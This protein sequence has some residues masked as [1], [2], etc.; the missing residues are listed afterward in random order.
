MTSPH[1]PSYPLDAAPAADRAVAAFMDSLARS[2]APRPR[3]VDPL[4]L[5]R[6]APLVARMARLQVRERRLFGVTIGLEIAVF[7]AAA[8]VVRDVLHGSLLRGILDIS[9]LGGSHGI[10][11]LLLLLAAVVIA[12]WTSGLV[13]AR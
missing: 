6:C 4:H 7:A 2:P 9:H 1:S 5:V 8:V 3:E 13:S 12:G 11:G 10:T